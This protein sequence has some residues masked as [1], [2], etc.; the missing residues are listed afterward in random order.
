MANYTIK[1]GDT[2][3]NIAKQHGTDWRTLYEA[4]KDAIGANPN[5]IRPGLTLT[6][7]GTDAPAPAPTAPASGVAPVSGVLGASDADIAAI[8]ALVEASLANKYE[9]QRL[10]MQQAY[11]QAAAELAAAD[12]AAQ[13]QYA[14]SEAALQTQQARDLEQ[15]LR[16]QERQQLASGWHSSA[17]AQQH[18]AGQTDLSETYANLLAEMMGQRDTTLQANAQQ[19]ALMA[20]QLGE[21]FAALT[22]QE[23]N[24]YAQMLYQML[25]DQYAAQRDL[26]RQMQYAQYTDKLRG[27]GG[28][29]G[30]SR[31]STMTYE[32][33]V[34]MLS[35]G[36]DIPGVPA[37]D[38]PGVPA[39]DS[40]LKGAPLV[41]PKVGLTDK[42]KKALRS[43]AGLK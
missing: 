16:S 28:G 33:L 22:T 36:S 41:K 17:M 11:D 1:S 30:T 5:L 14:A 37:Q 21:Q 27:S 23:Q 8:Q 18:Q 12:A 39:Q 31:D 40:P 34:G 7:P 20:K 2:L 15:L 25:Y 13:Q 35:G 6:I 43:G 32:E 3:S 9:P 42:E 24:A 38:S 10:A 26:E 29:S 4:N 19:R